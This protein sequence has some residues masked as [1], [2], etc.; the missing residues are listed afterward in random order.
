M[1][2]RRQNSR[3]SDSAI[4]APSGQ[5]AVFRNGRPEKYGLYDPANEHD[6]CGVG[7]VA[8]IKGQRSR[9]IVDDS[10]HMLNHMVHRGACGCEPNTGDGA[11]ILTALPYEFLERVAGDDLGVT[12]PDRGSYGVG[13]VFLPKDESERATCKQ[14]VNRVIEEEGQ[15]LLGWRDVPVDPDGADIGPSAR[16]AEP[17][18]EMLFVGAAD[19]I[20]QEDL[21]RKLFVIRKRCSHELRGSDLREALLFYVCSLSTKVLIYKGMLTSEQVPRYFTD[22]QDPDYTSHLAMVHSRFSTNTFPSWDRAQ[23]NRFMSHNG[24][25]NTLRGNANWMHARQGSLQSDL[26]G[27]DMSRMFPVIEADCSDSGNYDNALEFLY[28]AGRSLPEAVMMMIPEAWQ[29]HHSMS[30]QKRSFYEY[31]SAL[32]EP[33]DGPASISFTDGQYIGAVLDRNG[34][35]PS[36]FYVTHDDRVIM[37]SEV[38]VLEVEPSNVRQKG[39][40]QPGKMFL[41]DFEQGKIVTDEELKNDVATKRP[42]GEWLENQRV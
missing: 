35:R 2:S 28:H 9:Q 29:N 4:V 11:G 13:L 12:L 24:E 25:I 1:A 33:W 19:G 40:L 36:R 41:V 39:R 16:A 7:F 26:F 14:T 34:L 10:L 27:E 6:S 42:Y 22:L 21:D 8:H 18:V 17:A 37:A 38:G 15:V 5:A 31:H 30:E 32:Q 23:P 3:S 20:G